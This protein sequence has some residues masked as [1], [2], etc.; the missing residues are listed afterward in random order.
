MSSSWQDPI[1]HPLEKPSG[2]S[3]S[4]VRAWGKQQNVRGQAEGMGVP[5]QWVLL[6]GIEDMGL[7]WTWCPQLLKQCMKWLRG[8]Q[9]PEVARR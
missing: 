4:T 8:Q 9:V 5:I 7:A 2:C 3:T 6:C 1:L